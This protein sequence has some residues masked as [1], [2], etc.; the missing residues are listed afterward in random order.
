MMRASNVVDKRGSE[1]EGCVRGDKMD[2]VRR[3]AARKVGCDEEVVVLAVAGAETHA[4]HTR[5]FYIPGTEKDRVG[6]AHP[7]RRTGPTH[8]TKMRLNWVSRR[9]Q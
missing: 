2:G 8:K 1:R 7:S 9:G 6:C 4:A 3:G 5:L